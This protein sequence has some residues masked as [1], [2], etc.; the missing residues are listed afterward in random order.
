MCLVMVVLDE[1]LDFEGEF[2]TTAEVCIFWNFCILIKCMVVLR[3]VVFVLCE[4][5]M[6]VICKMF[7]VSEIC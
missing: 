4:D 1:D 3:E 2:L 6:N 7:K 5:F